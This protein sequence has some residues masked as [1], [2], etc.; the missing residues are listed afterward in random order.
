MKRGDFYTVSRI[1]FLE[2]GGDTG[3]NSLPL[4]I[5]KS[6]MDSGSSPE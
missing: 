3:M 5:K 2:E 1:E 6:P 4:G